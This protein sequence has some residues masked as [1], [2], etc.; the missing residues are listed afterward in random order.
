[1][2]FCNIVRRRRNKYKLKSGVVKNL[3]PIPSTLE[4]FLLLEYR[5]SEEKGFKPKNNNKKKLK[6]YICLNELKKVIS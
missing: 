6:K 5:L 3:N 1:M 4:S 2:I